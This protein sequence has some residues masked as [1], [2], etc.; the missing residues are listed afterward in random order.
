M[1]PRRQ[2]LWAD[3]QGTTILPVTR[4]FADTSVAP[5]SYLNIEAVW[6]QAGPLIVDIGV[7]HGES[8]FAGA[9]QHPQANF[10]AV[11]VYR[12]GLGKL[13][14]RVVSEGVTNVRL[15]E[16]DAHEVLDHMIPADA[17]QEIWIFFA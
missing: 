14:D 6:G 16:A 10:L 2:Q 15:V 9:V 13:L 7:G 1:S 17:A 8:T 3:H 12:P 4:S 11:E 5:E